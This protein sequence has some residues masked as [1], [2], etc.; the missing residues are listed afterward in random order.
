MRMLGVCLF[1]LLIGCGGGGGDT[2]PPGDIEA[3]KIASVDGPGR[4]GIRDAWSVTEVAGV[5]LSRPA[6]LSRQAMVALDRWV[7]RHAIPA[8]DGQGGGLA[9]MTVAADY[10]CRTRNNRPGAR[11]SEH[12]LGNAIDI[13]AF[14]LRDGTRLTV[15]DDWNSRNSGVMR[16][17]WRSA[18]GPFSTVLGPNS[19]A[20]HQDHFHFDVAQYRGG[21][22]CR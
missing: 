9:S 20:F 17:L 4:C 7:A 2:V 5:R 8:V 6:R 14:T 11:L 12:A 15:S 16:R 21:P 19:D 22:Y 13:S 3:V 1:T 10:A 18:C